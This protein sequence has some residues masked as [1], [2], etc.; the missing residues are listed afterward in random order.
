[1]KSHK[2]GCPPERGY[3]LENCVVGAEK[4]AWFAF[5]AIGWQRYPLA[6]A[7]AAVKGLTRPSRAFFGPELAFLFPAHGAVIAFVRLN[8]LLL[9][10]GGIGSQYEFTD[11]CVPSK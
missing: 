8:A 6:Q 4:A 10:N 5:I 7:S 2:T 9:L 1:M 11:N 3:D